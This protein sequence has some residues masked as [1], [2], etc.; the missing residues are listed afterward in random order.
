M[1]AGRNRGYTHFFEMFFLTVANRDYYL[2]HSEHMSVVGKMIDLG[3]SAASE[4]FCAIDS[5]ATFT[6]GIEKIFLRIF[7]ERH[8]I[9]V[10]E[11]FEKIDDESLRAKAKAAYQDC[12]ANR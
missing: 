8:K 9:T 7:E 6:P 1:K 4:D 3:F 12:S 11:S 5:D 10:A 2:P